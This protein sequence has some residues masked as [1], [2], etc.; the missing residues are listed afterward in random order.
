MTIDD[1]RLRTNVRMYYR[2]RLG[3]AAMSFDAFVFF[4]F[5]FFF[6]PLED[7]SH[8]RGAMKKAIEMG[9]ITVGRRY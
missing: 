5:F 7:T 9:R 8:E 4:F 6:F 1:S 2:R 3:I